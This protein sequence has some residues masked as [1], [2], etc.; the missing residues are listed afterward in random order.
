MNDIT[1]L[2]DTT[3]SY[4][5]KEIVDLPDP[6]V[7]PLVH[8]LDLPPARPDFRHYWLATT[9]ASPSVGLCL[10]AIIW[11]AS[12]SYVPPI[13]AGVAVIVFGLVTQHVKANRAW[14][15]V[16]R[17]RQDRR[18]PLPL[19]WDLIGALVAAAALFVTLFLVANRLSQSD[20][21]RDVRD[22]TFGIAAAVALLMLAEFAVRLVVA[23]R[24][25]LLSLPAIAAVLGIV[26]IAYRD[27]SGA[28]WWGAGGMLLFGVTVGTWKVLG[29]GVTT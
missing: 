18:R 25:A 22:S 6:A 28:T 12:H 23:R 2:N 29:R 10:A 5:I 13:I 16:P 21:S 17:K 20:V 3:E 9:F 8:P 7:Q 14:D 24:Q 27:V 15:F 19:T 1:E 11:F 4:D 26:V